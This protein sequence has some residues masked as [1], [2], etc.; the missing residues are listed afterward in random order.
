MA[1]WSHPRAGSR[2]L[3]RGTQQHR[4]GRRAVPTTTSVSCFLLFGRDGLAEPDLIESGAPRNLLSVEGRRG[5]EDVEADLVLG[6]VYRAVETDA[7]QLPR[8]FRRR[9]ACSAFAEGKLC[10]SAASKVCLHEVARHPVDATTGA[11]GSKRQ[12]V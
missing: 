3:F 11:D 1:G 5:F 8:Q 12:N 4:R 9:R 2:E 7:R 10:R 6:Y